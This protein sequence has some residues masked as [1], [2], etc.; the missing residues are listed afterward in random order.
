M[1]TVV[2]SFLGSSCAV[3]VSRDSSGSLLFILTQTAGMFSKDTAF[4]HALSSVPSQ[5]LTAIKGS[6]L[7]QRGVL[8]AYIDGVL[9][10][11]TD[12]GRHYGYGYCYSY[13][14]GYRI[15]G[16]YLFSRFVFA[17]CSA[18]SPLRRPLLVLCRSQL[19]NASAPGKEKGCKEEDWCGGGKGR[20]V[21]GSHV[22]C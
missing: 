18:L 16:P 17:R 20:T 4:Q 11:G 10:G 3:C 12:G 5:L 21:E 9:E 7:D 13:C 19:R 15:N 8:V 6:A 1:C 22:R 2:P 14:Y